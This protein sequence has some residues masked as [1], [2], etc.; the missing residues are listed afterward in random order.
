MRKIDRQTARVLQQIQIE[1]LKKSGYFDGLLQHIDDD[2]YDREVLPHYG[3]IPDWY[4]R[5]RD[6][7][8]KVKEYLNEDIYS[9]E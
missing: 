6:L 9:D 2:E 1:N 7:K 5:W 8:N 4:V 3:L